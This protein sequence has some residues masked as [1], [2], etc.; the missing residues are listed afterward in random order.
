MRRLWTSAMFGGL[1]LCAAAVTSGEAR[2]HFRL[3]APPAMTEQNDLGDPQK[4][5][6]C[7]GDSNAVMT[8]ATT[9]FTAGDTITITINEE[10]YHPGHYRV[11]LAPNDVSELPADPPI[12]PGPGD[13]CA[14]TE[15]MDPPVFPVIADGMLAHAEP[16]DGEQ[17]FEV[18][19]PEDVSCDNCTLQVIQYMSSH[20][21][22]CFYYH[23]AE[24]S[25]APGAS[26]ETGDPGTTTGEP[27]TSG[28]PGT[29][30]GSPDPTG[31][32]GETSNGATQSGGD[33]DP[34][35]AGS[36]GSTTGAGT[37]TGGMGQDDSSGGG[38]CAASR[39]QRSGLLALVPVLLVLR[40]RRH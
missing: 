32:P 37:G 40:R 11:A 21:A 35:A 30:S 7:G 12:T 1:A 6:P 39:P 16:F 2:A 28:E 4:V 36:S 15:I 3:E 23:C 33:P 19:L 9:S 17:S 10:I 34:T 25:I 38:G 31:T 29:T 22:P 27:G 24:I 5:Y 8:G 13:E 20:G 26:G 18:T 14:M